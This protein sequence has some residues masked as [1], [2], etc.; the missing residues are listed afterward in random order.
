MPANTNGGLTTTVIADGATATTQVSG[1]NTTKLATTA[2]A[3][4]HRPIFA[5]NLS[6]SVNAFSSGSWNS[7][8][9]TSQV[10]AFGSTAITNVIVNFNATSASSNT[11]LSTWRMGIDGT[12][13]T[14]GVVIYFNSTG[15]HHTMAGTG[16]ITGISLTGNHTLA[17]YV[18]PAMAGLA[19]NTDDTQCWTIM[20]YTA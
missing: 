20:G 9:G 6:N 4:L 10:V 2:H 14:G 16:I 7:V 1:D 5:T 15:F 11:G 18:Y 3:R 12:Y 19:T 8:S 13:Y 17:M